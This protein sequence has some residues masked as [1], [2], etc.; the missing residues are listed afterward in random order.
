MTPE[1]YRR[2]CGRL[3]RK[4]LR[5]A[6]EMANN[7][8]IIATRVACPKCDR[9]TGEPCKFPV[10]APDSG[11][12]APKGF[13]HNERAVAAR[14]AEREHWID[15][16]MDVRLPDIDDDV[17]LEVTSHAKAYEESTGTPAPSREIAA[18]HAFQADVWEAINQTE[19]A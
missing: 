2:I 8:E 5:F 4:A 10:W 15:V 18:V 3:A 7:E 1:E 16:F 17:L 6:E 11:H 14:D 12:D 9:P 13:V 19:A